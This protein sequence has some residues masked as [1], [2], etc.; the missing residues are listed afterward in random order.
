VCVADP[1]A[2]EA[3]CVPLTRSLF[4]GVEDSQHVGLGDE[5]GNAGQDPDSGG[6]MLVTEQLSQCLFHIA[7]VVH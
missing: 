4:A 1:P 2:Y 3:C 6:W 5:P 7:V